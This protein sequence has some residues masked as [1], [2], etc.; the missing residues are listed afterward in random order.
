MKLTFLIYAPW[1]RSGQFVYPIK[2]SEGPAWSK[3]TGVGFVYKLMNSNFG[4]T[5]QVCDPAASIH[6]R[7]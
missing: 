4:Y 7:I 1:F 5:K 3:P 2:Q 6:A